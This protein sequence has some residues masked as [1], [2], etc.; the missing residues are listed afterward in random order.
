MPWSLLCTSRFSSPDQKKKKK[1]VHKF[2]MALEKKNLE[3]YSEKLRVKNASYLSAWHL[4]SKEQDASFKLWQSFATK[5]CLTLQVPCEHMERASW[6][7]SCHKE[8]D[9]GKY[10]FTGSRINWWHRYTDSYLDTEDRTAAIWRCLFLE[11][12]AWSYY[13]FTK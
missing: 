6:A 3:F 12:I 9:S 10:A 8:V 11:M 2:L 4:H 5:F 13:N 7:G 1:M